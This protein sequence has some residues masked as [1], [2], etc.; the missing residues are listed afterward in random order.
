[1]SVNYNGQVLAEWPE[2]ME[3]VQRGLFYGDALF[4]SMRLYDGR[5]PL[6]GY[7]WERLSG[8]LRAMGYA[9]PFS[10]SA[11]FFEKEIQRAT[12]SNARVRLTVWRAPGGLWVPENDEP[13]FLIT[14]KAM[15][16][17]PFT[18]M[19]SGLAIGICQS[20][21]LP[22]DSL[23]GFKT[24]NGARYVA[25][26]LESKAKGWDEGLVLNAFNRICEATSSN[27]FWFEGEELF[28]PPLTDGG[29]TGT[30]QKL[31]LLLR[32]E[33]GLPVHEKPAIFAT[34]KE[35]DEV[36]LTN[37]VQGIR[38]VRNFEGKVLNHGKTRALYEKVVGRLA[39]KTS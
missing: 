9:I 13:R 6:M 36:F 33:A 3:A 4:E 32:S 38:W 5:I 7:H 21:R 37:A 11:D 17:A 14:A 26:A 30:F 31:L 24:V 19:D 8:G 1:M 25:A 39:P 20:V 27:L 2:N 15:E 34:L 18:W 23:S 10:W 12:W 16:S 28:T 22:V 35:A 29:V